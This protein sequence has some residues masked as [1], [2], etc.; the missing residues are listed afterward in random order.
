MACCGGRPCGGPADGI[1]PDRVLEEVQSRYPNARP[2]KETWAAAAN[3]QPQFDDYD[4]GLDVAGDA[5]DPFVYAGA[6]LHACNFPLGGFGCGRVL[7]CGD[8][9]LKEWTVVNQC[10]SDDGGPWDARQP[11]H[12]MPANFFA[13]SATPQGGA[14]Q[15][16]ALISP[17]TY[18]EENTALPSRREAHVSQHEVARAPAF[19]SARARLKTSDSRMTCGSSG[20]GL[21]HTKRSHAAVRLWYD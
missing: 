16:Y 18:T 1:E 3:G 8:G 13:V 7:L 6:H 15:T 4:D 11:L 14:K 19:H 2:K 5:R 9:T 10:R 21:Q 17:Q 20:W 12:C